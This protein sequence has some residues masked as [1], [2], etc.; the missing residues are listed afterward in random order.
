[1]ASHILETSGSS[2]AASTALDCA[3]PWGRL[4]LL[5]LG[6]RVEFAVRDVFRRQLTVMTS[7]TMPR[8]DQKRCAEFVVDRSLPIEELFSHHWHLDQIVEAYRIFDA[9][10]AGK[11]VIEF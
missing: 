10:D 4:C 9:Q 11:G 8:H 1:M 5:G 2:A 7:W 6:G 3:V